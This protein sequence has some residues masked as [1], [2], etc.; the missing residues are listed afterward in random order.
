MVKLVLII[1][2]TK[3]RIWIQKN[4]IKISNK[5]YLDKNIKI[6]NIIKN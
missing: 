1:F 5:L 2:N 4:Y 3:K 6:K